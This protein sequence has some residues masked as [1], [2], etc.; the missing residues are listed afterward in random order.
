MK[1]TDLQ[2]ESFAHARMNHLFSVPESY[3]VSQHHVKSH[4]NQ[5]C[6]QIKQF[7]SKR[8]YQS[9][10]PRG[11]IDPYHA[12]KDFRQQYRRYHLHS[13]LPQAKNPQIE[14]EITQHIELNTFGSLPC[15]K[16]LATS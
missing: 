12:K 16:T 9:S 4:V 14:P 7:Y 11:M 10:Q 13:Y 15:A 8:K 3:K 2:Q 6:T 5:Q 1:L